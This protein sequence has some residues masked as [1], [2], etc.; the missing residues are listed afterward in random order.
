MRPEDAQELIGQRRVWNTHLGPQIVT[1]MRATGT[2]NIDAT[3]CRINIDQ[4]WCEYPLP[5]GRMDSLWFI[6]EQFK[7]FSMSEPAEQIS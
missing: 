2:V 4:L 6:P 5:N 3:N 7:S 1:C